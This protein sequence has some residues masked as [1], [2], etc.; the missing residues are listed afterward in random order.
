LGIWSGAGAEPL[1]KEV[2]ARVNGTPIAR[3]TATE[4]FE[5]SV[6]QLDAPLPPAEAAA[7]RKEALDS[8]IEFELLYQESQARHLRVSDSAVAD[9]IRTTQDRFGS[10]A[11]YRQALSEKGLT[12][13]DIERDTRKTLAVDRLLA[14]AV[15]NRVSVTDAEVKQFYGEHS[16]EFRHPTQVRA[17][18]IL[19]RLPPGERERAMARSKAEAL[20]KRAQGGEDFAAL[21]RAESEDKITALQGGDLGY[22]EQ[23][24][25]VA[26]VDEVAFRLEPGQVS[27]VVQTPH[28][29]HVIKVT[30][31]RTAGIAPL[32]EVRERI[33]TLLTREKRQRLQEELVAE[34]R[35][36]AT[37]EI[38]PDFR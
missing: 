10:P 35:R 26:A 5:A 19:I 14:E 28:G 31:R 8:L 6:A 3:R 2:A 9:T 13:Q 1:S 36:Q 7:L 18:H 16:Q 4:V 17:S 21:A 32:D 37:V 15:W 29:L 24:A 11:A 30:G 23:G 33:V 22:F 20:A 27:G 38:A 25:M 34:L 12:P